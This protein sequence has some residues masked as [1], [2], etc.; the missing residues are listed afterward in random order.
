MKKVFVCFI[1][2]LF[3][4]PVMAF[5]DGK[6]DFNARCAKCH[7]GDAKAIT[8]RANILK[9]DPKKLALQASEM[10]DAEMMTVIE[11]GRNQMPAFE[12]ELTKE[13]IK[14]IVDYIRTLK[15]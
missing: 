9:I 15:K 4:T 6:A 13:Q 7:G 1:L 10:N 3:V 11:K 8:K 14:A 5:A 2:V 12:K